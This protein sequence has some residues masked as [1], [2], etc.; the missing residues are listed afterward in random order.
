M[1]CLVMGMFWRLFRLLVA[2]RLVS[3]VGLRKSFVGQT[4]LFLGFWF[5]WQCSVWASEDCFSECYCG[6]VAEE[7]CHSGY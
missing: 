4:G 3:V 7:Y 5:V 1:S 2:V 6:D